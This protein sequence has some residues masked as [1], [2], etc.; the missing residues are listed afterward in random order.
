MVL[1]ITF[2]VI[3]PEFTVVS[4]LKMLLTIHAFMVTIGKRVRLVGVARFN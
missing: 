1:Y 4:G 2:P 3:L